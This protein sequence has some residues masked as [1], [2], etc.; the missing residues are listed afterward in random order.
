MIAIFYKAHKIFLKLCKINSIEEE[1][2]DDYANIYHGKENW[3]YIPDRQVWIQNKP[4][5]LFRLLIFINLFLS[6]Y[7]T[8]FFNTNVFSNTI[9]EGPEFLSWSKNLVAIPTVCDYKNWNLVSESNSFISL[10]RLPFELAV[11]H[12]YAHLDPCKVFNMELFANINNNF[13]PLTVFVKKLHLRYLRG[14]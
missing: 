7:A 3:P 5:K 1:A 11:M 14:F 12:A 10:L 9:L 4:F 2:W 13:Q 6:F 8:S